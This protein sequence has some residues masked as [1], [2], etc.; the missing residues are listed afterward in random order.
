MPNGVNLLQKRQKLAKLAEFGFAKDLAE[1]LV[2]TLGMDPIGQL[3]DAAIAEALTEEGLVDLASVKIVAGAASRHGHCRAVSS[4]HG[5]GDGNEV[6]I[7]SESEGME[8]EEEKEPGAHSVCKD[9]VPERASLG[10]AGT[11]EGN[12]LAS[13]ERR[14]P[15][16]ALGFFAEA[17]LALLDIAEGKLYSFAGHASFKAYIRRS[18]AVL[19]FG[20][21]QARNLIAAARV[22]RNLPAGVARPS[23][24]MQ[25]RPFVGCHPDVQLKAWV[26]ALGRAG[27]LESARVSGRLVRECLREVKGSLADD[28]L[29]GSAVVA[30][31][32]DATGMAADGD[33]RH[34]DALSLQYGGLRVFMQ[35]DTC[36]WY[37]PDF[38]L[39]LVRE[40][41]T[42]GCIDLDPC[43]CA[44]ANTRVRATSFYDEATDGLAEGSAWRGNPAFGVRRGQSLQG[45]FFGRCMREYQ[46]GNVRQAVVLLILKAGIGYS[47]FN[48]VL[49]WPVCFL[50][51]HLS[52]V[53]QVGT[54]DELQ[55]GARAQNPHGSVIV[56]MGP[57]VERFATLFSRIGSVPGMNS[58][59]HVRPVLP[60]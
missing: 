57:A 27:G 59:P 26:L 14:V 45:L 8:E 47:W 16:A 54:S 43:S 7:D 36:E 9:G 49:N 30:T 19:G 6:A 12:A 38:I 46:A 18:L 5:T 56:Y 24:Q 34:E 50:R 52:F 37:T 23:N 1:V 28:V 60:R 25:V 35:S 42:P 22:I 13:A 29:A 31:P 21:H 55:W 17:S 20:L 10:R 41:F 33:T 58:W 51:E 3:T 32:S 44:A 39:D 2:E 4:G 40:L 48:D 11:G 15:M 53:R